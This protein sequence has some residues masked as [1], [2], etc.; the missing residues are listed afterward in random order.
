LSRIP[1]LHEGGNAIDPARHVDAASGRDSDDDLSIRIDQRAN[2]VVLTERQRKRAVRRLAF[3]L[4]VEP[5]RRDHDIRLRGHRLRHWIHE[6]LVVNDPQSRGGVSPLGA[7]V[8]LEPHAMRTVRQIDARMRDER[9]AKPPVI[10]QELVVDVNAI[11]AIATCRLNGN[12]MW[13]RLFRREVAAPSRRGSFPAI[14]PFEERPRE[15]DARIDA[16]DSR[17]S[18]QSGI[19]KPFE[20]EAGAAAAIISGELHPIGELGDWRNPSVI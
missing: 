11:P 12:P 3:A 13:S 18:G 17:A 4:G 7:A 15:V 19:R 16:S 9:L 2:Q 14:G 8:L 10:Q 5:N 1:G 20:V 6:L